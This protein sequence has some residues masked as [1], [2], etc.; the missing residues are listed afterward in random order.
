MGCIIAIITGIFNIFYSTL[1][2]PDIWGWAAGIICYTLVLAYVLK[3]VTKNIKIRKTVIKISLTEKLIVIFIIIGA[4]IAMITGLRTI[5][6]ISYTSKLIF[7]QT[8]YLNITLILSV[9]YISSFGFLWYIEKNIT[10]PI[11]TISDIVKNYVSDSDGLGNSAYLI[12]QCELYATENSEIGILAGSFQKMGRDVKIYMNN[13]QRVTSEK[14]KIN[15]ELNVARRIQVDMLPRNF[16]INPEKL[17]YDIYATTKPAKEVGGDFYDFFMIDDDSLAIVIA[18]VSGKGVPA[19]LFMVIAK[20]LIKNYT[21]LGKSPSEVFTTVNNQLYDGNDENMFVTAWMGILEI[22]TGKFTY[23]NA[24]HTTPLIK[25]AGGNYNWLTS[26]PNFVLGGMQNI[27]YTQNEILLSQG[28][29]IYLYT[30]GVTES[31]NSDNE[32]F[33]TSLLYR[34]MNKKDNPDLKEQLSYVKEK[35]DIFVKG[36]KQFDDITMLIMEYKKN[37]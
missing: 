3:P 15:T 16:P 14:Q 37:I 4:I 27:Q 18:D 20:T 19:A 35:I 31:I 12:S 33:G 11:E 29:R 25:Q 23:V 13:L 36:R 30:D 2:A 32:M 22:K 6:T 28:D 24:G 17:G 9:F 34:V 8:V 5:F 26:Q 1:D 10:T 21:Q 7:W